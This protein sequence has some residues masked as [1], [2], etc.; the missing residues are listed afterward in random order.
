[1]LAAAGPYLKDARDSRA[2]NVGGFAQVHRIRRRE[3][4]R[5]Q[6]QLVKRSSGDDSLTPGLRSLGLVERFEARAL[7]SR[8]RER[9]CARRRRHPPRPRFTLSHSTRCRRR[10]RERCR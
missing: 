4:L 7:A 3:K 5:V 6:T 10:R 1:M 9:L 2:L 8:V